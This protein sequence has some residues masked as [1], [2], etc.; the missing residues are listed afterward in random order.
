MSDYDV[1]VCGHHYDFWYFDIEGESFSFEI[2]CL[3][4]WTQ[5]WTFYLGVDIVV[6]IFV[7][8]RGLDHNVC[9]YRG[10]ALL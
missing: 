4:G 1:L 5:V 7:Y 8:Y 3:R 2:L 9:V 10:V 6:D